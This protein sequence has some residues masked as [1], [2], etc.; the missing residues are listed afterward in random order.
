MKLGKWIG[1]G[2]GWAFAGPIGAIL[3]FAIGSVFDMDIK[4]HR[5]T[6]VTHRADFMLSMLVLIAAVMKA[7][8]RVLKSELEYVK[9]FLISNFGPETASQSLLVLRD[10]LKKDIRIDD[11]TGQIAANMNYEMRLQM[12]HFLFGLANAD[13]VITSHEIIV[14]KDIARK[15][16]MSEGDIKSVM[17]M[18]VSDTTS[19]YRILEVSPEASNEDIK[20]AYRALAKKH[21]PDLVSNLGPD[22][23]KAAHEKF[24][25]INEA[26]ET[27]KKE[28]GIV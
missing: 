3:G 16:G 21:H 17:A 10:I 11:V 25:K 22:I 13:G 4:V 26:Y 23:Q 20:K 9:R 8:G 14:I 7:D 12:L 2:L 6:G 1:G 28:R 24:R 18:F 27:I 15:L 19:A 5:Q